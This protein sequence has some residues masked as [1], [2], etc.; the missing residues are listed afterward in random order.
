MYFLS[1]PEI[2]AF[3]RREFSQLLLVNDQFSK[4]MLGSWSFKAAPF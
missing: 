2:Y 1:L 3:Q 4:A